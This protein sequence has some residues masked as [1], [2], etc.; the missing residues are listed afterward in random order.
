MGWVRV[1]RAEAVV[2]V[3]AAAAVVV[4]VVVQAVVTGILV[5]VVALLAA[6][7]QVLACRLLDDRS[8]KEQAP[9]DGAL[10]AALGAAGIIAEGGRGAHHPPHLL[11][12]KRTGGCCRDR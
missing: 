9:R 7:H 2:V 12:M 8:R 4:V 10:G 3:E 5:G 6:V 11:R 1:V